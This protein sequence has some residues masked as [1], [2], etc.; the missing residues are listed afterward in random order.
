[1]SVAI[2]AVPQM[3]ENTG[4]YQ[5]MQRLRVLF[6][7]FLFCLFLPL[8]RLAD[9]VVILSPNNFLYAATLT[10]LVSAFIL[11]P[12]YLLMRFKRWFIPFAAGALFTLAYFIN[13]LS[14]QTTLHPE[15]NHCGDFTYTG[16]LYPIHDYLNDSNTDDLLIRNQLC[17]V[18]KMVKKIPPE[19]IEGAYLIQ[20]HKKLM[21]PKDKFQVTLPL[22][23][24]LHGE[25]AFKSNNPK[26]LYDS[27]QFWKE[28]YTL[29]LKN[30]EY[31]WW[32]WPLSSWMKFEY[33]LIENNWESIVDNIRVEE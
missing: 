27:L 8:W 23:A 21:L 1:M 2:I 4:K 3:Q 31:H 29:Q 17:W 30:K 32:D 26:F 6:A 10:L 9:Y 28:H 18:R 11:L 12:L 5:D 24:I 14:S 33:G 7:V 20:T 22:I 13:P 15:L 16:F 19:S 25:L